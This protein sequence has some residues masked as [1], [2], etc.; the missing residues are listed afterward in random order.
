[1]MNKLLFADPPENVVISGGEEVYV[2][3]SV[4]CQADADP[5]V[6]NNYTWTINGT[7]QQTGK[8]IDISAL[9]EHDIKCYATNTIR[10][11]PYTSCVNK[12]ITGI[13]E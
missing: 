10:S 13:C 6:D 9:G 5:A 1:M 8:Q 7:D 12:T 2:G 11:A 3:D 4:S